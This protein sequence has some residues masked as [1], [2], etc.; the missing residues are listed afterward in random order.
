MAEQDDSVHETLRRERL[1]EE[2][3]YLGNPE[4]FKQVWSHAD[5]VSLFGAFGPCKTG[6]PQLSRILDWLASRYRDGIVSSDYEVVYEGTDVAYTVGYERG[7]VSLDGGPKREQT[8]R[9]THIY[10]RE[11]GQWRL[12][13]RHGDFAPV[14]QSV[15][16]SGNTPG[17]P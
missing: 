6:W 11:N 12:A 10:R 1:A 5:D 3:L 13:H 17:P 4:P 14:D 15:E 16:T 7:E 8:L 2:A 9:V